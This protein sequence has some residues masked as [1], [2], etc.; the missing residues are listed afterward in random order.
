MISSAV[1]DW[2]K[3]LIIGIPPP[4]LASKRKFLFIFSES[5]N[6]SGPYFAT[7][8]LLEVQ[9]LFP[10]S[11]EAFAKE[12][13]GLIPPI[14]STTISTSSSFT[15]VSKSCTRIFSIEEPGNSLKSRTYL[16]LISSPILFAILSLFVLITSTTPEP[17]VPYPNTAIFIMSLSPFSC[18]SISQLRSL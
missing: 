11:R 16:I 4:T 13:A 10:C 8:S 1:R 12:Y 7:S 2:F 15:I 14:A 6:N 5:F 3:G 18:Y 9:Q 17:T